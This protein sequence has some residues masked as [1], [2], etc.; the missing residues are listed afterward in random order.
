MKWI[1]WIP[2]FSAAK[3]VALLLALV[4]LAGIGWK[5]YHTGKVDGRVEVQNTFDAYINAQTASALS[6]SMARR[7]REETYQT[8]YAKAKNEAA[9]HKA[10]RIADGIALDDVLR[11]FE[12]A[13]KTPD[14]GTGN[15]VTEP[16]TGTNG[17]G[18]L[19]RELLNH[20]AAVVVG[21]AK[22][23]DRLEGQVVGLQN[24]IRSIGL[25]P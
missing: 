10:L 13:G 3:L 15:E 4:T 19:E 1:N 20:C 6:E 5:I 11:Q 7:H 2:G 18:G 16:G 12:A 8:N 9:E 22:T 23:A 25:Y 17:T 24:Y 21:L 14:S